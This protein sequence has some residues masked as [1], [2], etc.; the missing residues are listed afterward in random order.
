MTRD[1][2]LDLLARQ[3]GEK[4]RKRRTEHTESDLQRQCVSWFRL[5]YPTDALMLFA[6][7]N[8]GGRSVVEAGTK[9]HTFLIPQFPQ[10]FWG[11]KFGWCVPSL[12]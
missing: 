9:H 11:E 6:V 10:Q 7:P 1:A 3:E 5:Q 12:T 8:G 2:Y 4:K